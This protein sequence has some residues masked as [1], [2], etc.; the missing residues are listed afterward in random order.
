VALNFGSVTA[1]TIPEGSVRR[2]LQGETV[3]WSKIKTTTYTF[4]VKAENAEGYDMR[5][6][7]IKVLGVRNSYDYELSY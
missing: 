2:I 3:L 7:T 5:E 1:V 6:F 4:T